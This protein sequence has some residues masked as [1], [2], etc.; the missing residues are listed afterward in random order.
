M[1]DV[2]DYLIGNN[3]MMPHGFCFLWKPSLLWLF[4]VS[5]GVIALSYFSI[6]IA[7]AVFAYQRKDV[8]FKWILLL[9][10]TFIFACSITHVLT[11]VTIW[12]PVYGLA[13]IAEA[14]T[15][16]VSAVTA[17][18]LWPLIPKALRIPSLSSLVLANK[19]LAN[20]ILCHKETQAQLN[21]L[22][23]ELDHL[24]QMRTR[25]LQASE[26]DLRLSQI[27]GGIGSWKADL[28]THKQI[29]SDNCIGL[30]GFPA[31]S[32]PTWEDFLEAIHPEDRQ[33]VISATQ[34]HIES[35]AKYDVEYR[36]ITTNGNIR[37]L[38]SVGQIE[39]DADG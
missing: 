26:A 15:A 38:H 39:R 8:N 14:L 29:W 10:S 28:F 22:N 24:V 25:E 34:S 17:V 7:L 23:T 20:E 32:D 4:V 33:Q 30:L 16:I 9:F 27:S 1:Q 37:W 35:G 31:L 11:V 3:G 2:I 13:A 19:K 21:Q 12:N 36:I 18:L 6:P 5:N